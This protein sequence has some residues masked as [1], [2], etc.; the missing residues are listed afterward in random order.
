MT[1]DDR[2]VEEASLAIGEKERTMRVHDVL[3]ALIARA[4]ARAILV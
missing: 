2:L 3:R 1:L 4:N